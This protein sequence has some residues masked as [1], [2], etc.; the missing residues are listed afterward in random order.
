MKETIIWPFVDRIKDLIAL[1]N[2]FIVKHHNDN[3]IHWIYINIYKLLF[4]KI[5][6]LVWFVWEFDVWQKKIFLFLAFTD[7]LAS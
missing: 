1:S 2:S 7:L 3:E 4:N 5:N 6:L